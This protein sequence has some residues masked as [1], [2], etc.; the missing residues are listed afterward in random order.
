MLHLKPPELTEPAQDV[1]RETKLTSSFSVATRN[2]GRPMCSDL[3][4]RIQTH[5][6]ADSTPSRNTHRW[7]QSPK[8]T[9]TPSTGTPTG[10]S[11][12]ST[13]TSR[14]PCLSVCCS[15]TLS[16]GIVSKFLLE[17]TDINGIKHFPSHASRIQLGIWDASNPAGTSSWAKGPID[18]DTTPPRVTAVV[19]SVTVECPY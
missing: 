12:A 9:R 18:W 1:I 5:T 7:D 3:V 14:G 11:G 4:L 15:Y 2:T 6:T 19:K 17:D 10:S 16:L 13:G 8:P